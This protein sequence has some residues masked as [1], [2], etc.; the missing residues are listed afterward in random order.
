MK[1]GIV[2]RTS[3]QIKIESKTKIIKCLERSVWGTG[4]G[5]MNRKKYNNVVDLNPT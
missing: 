2:S 3:R 4:N 1:R 5:G